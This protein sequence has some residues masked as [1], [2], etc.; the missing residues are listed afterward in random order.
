MKI[1]L[2]TINRNNNSGLRRTIRSVQAQKRFLPAG[3]VVQHIVVDGWSTDGSVQLVENN[4][5]IKLVTTEPKGVYDAINHGIETATGDIVGLLHSGDIFSNDSVLSKIAT[6]FNTKEAPDFVWG[7]SR[8]GRRLYSGKDFTPDKLITGF[9]PPHLSLYMTAETLASVGLYDE[10]YR[11]AADFDYFVRLFN[12]PRLHGFYSPFICI[13]ME[14]GGLSQTL[15]YRLWHNNRER[16][17]SLR[18]NGLPASL[19]NIIKHYRH[20]IKG[21][22][23]SSKNQK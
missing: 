21:Y 7:D 16:L 15:S 23:C 10:T 1:S 5:D 6:V 3:V 17:R 14:P 19:F 18:S 13:D 22:L 20:V 2:I 4:A 9:S 8:I 12:N 11:T